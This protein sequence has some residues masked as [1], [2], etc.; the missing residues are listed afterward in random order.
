MPFSRNSRRERLGSTGR[1]GGG[2]PYR[3]PDASEDERGV[4]DEEQAQVL[5]VVVLRHAGEQRT[6]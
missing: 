3:C 2:A 4:D 6:R 5:R 1:K